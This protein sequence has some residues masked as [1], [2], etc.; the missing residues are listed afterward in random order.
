MEL[1]PGGACGVGAGMSWGLLG[2]GL[3]GVDSQRLWERRG[4]GFTVART[5]GYAWRLM[6]RRLI[7]HA[8]TPKPQTP[9]PPQVCR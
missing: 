5:C 3:I 4:H 8:P 2:V 7:F 9:K 6:Q 1:A